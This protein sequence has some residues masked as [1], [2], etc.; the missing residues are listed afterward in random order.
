MIPSALNLNPRFTGCG[1]QIA[2]K[3]WWP[4]HTVWSHRV[5]GVN[6]GYWTERN[7]KWY[8]DRLGELKSGKAQPLTSSQWTAR[9]KGYRPASIV[10]WN[11][12]AWALKII[13]TRDV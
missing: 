10:K 6:A 1:D 11:S 2:I 7:E 9:C 12:E 5:S 3:S 8:Q 4:T 13:S